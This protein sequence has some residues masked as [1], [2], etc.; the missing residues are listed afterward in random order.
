[1][2]SATKLPEVL[3]LVISDEAD[4]EAR[5]I[6][7]TDKG[8]FWSNDGKEWTQSA[9]SNFPIRVQ[10]IVRFNHTRSFAATSEGVFTTRDGGKNWGRVRGGKN[11]HAGLP[12]GGLRRPSARAV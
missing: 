4:A 3:S 11:R 7:G 6:A 2:L 10:K 5:F 9:P 12:R 8:F 1:M